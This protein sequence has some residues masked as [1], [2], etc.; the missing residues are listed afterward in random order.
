[1]FPPP[2]HELEAEVMEEV[3]HGGERT[4]RDVLDPINARTATQRAYTTILTVMQRLDAKD[5]LRRERH[6]RRDAYVPALTREG[7]RDQERPTSRCRTARR[8]CA[9][10]GPARSPCG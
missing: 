3:W 2:L 5:L 10:P 6:G 8:A 1:V 9:P 7:G 4:V